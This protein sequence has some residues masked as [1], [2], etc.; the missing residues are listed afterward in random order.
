M[1]RWYGYVVTAC[2]VRSV[3]V[4]DNKSR[5][6]EEVARKLASQ[7]AEQAQLGVGARGFELLS[8]ILDFRISN[9]IIGKI[10]TLVF[11]IYWYHLEKMSDKS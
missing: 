10:G 7:Q 4:C 9:F 3:S 11:R 8:K 6:R 1:R 2:Y 5:E